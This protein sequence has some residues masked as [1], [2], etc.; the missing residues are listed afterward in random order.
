MYIKY[1]PVPIIAVTNVISVI[2]NGDEPVLIDNTTMALSWSSSPSTLF[3]GVE[4]M[5]GI[6][7]SFSSILISATFTFCPR[8]VSEFCH[9]N[10]TCT[11]ALSPG[12]NNVSFKW[13]VVIIP[14]SFCTQPVALLSAGSKYNPAGIL[15]VIS[16]A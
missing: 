2:Y 8:F 10:T 12:F 3:P 4:S 11:V 6:S 13:S 15:S 14:S 9:L 16:F 1:S 5:S 7:Y